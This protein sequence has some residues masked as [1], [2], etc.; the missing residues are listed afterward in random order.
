MSTVQDID[1]RIAELDE[2]IRQ[3]RTKR[4]SLM[5]LFGLPSEILAHIMIILQNVETQTSFSFET[6]KGFNKDWV[7]F[8]HT[9]SRM[10]QIALETPSFWTFIDLTGCAQKEPPWL[11]LALRRSGDA[12]L[13]IFA[14]DQTQLSLYTPYMPRAML[15]CLSSASPHADGPLVKALDQPMPQ[16]RD[17]DLLYTSFLVSR[18]FLGGESHALRN[19]Q[20]TDSS[21]HFSTPRSP[22]LQ[23]LSPKRVYVGRS[24]HNLYKLLEGC[25]RIEQLHIEGLGLG[26]TLKYDHSESHPV[27]STQDLVP[28]LTSLWLLGHSAE[29]NWTLKSALREPKSTLCISGRD[30]GLESTPP[31]LMKLPLTGHH[32]KIIR[33][34]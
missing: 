16:I 4:N 30:P 1:H 8:T 27:Q 11:E 25:P 29:M 33:R 20:L 15:L 21:I 12:G 7:H 19:L 5:L 14:K 10:R 3:L 17:I 26:A 23:Q 32:E 24:Y 2:E 18:A 34:L 22:N 28:E 9:C 13:A 31:Y 6:L